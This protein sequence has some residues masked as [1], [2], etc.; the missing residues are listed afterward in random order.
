M[1]KPAV[2]KSPLTH[3]PLLLTREMPYVLPPMEFLAILLFSLPLQADTGDLRY[4]LETLYNEVDLLVR[5]QRSDQSGRARIERAFKALKVFDRI[6]MQPKIDTL[7]AELAHRAEEAGVGLVK[8]EVLGKD[9]PKK[10]LP[11]VLVSDTPHFA[12]SPDQIAE[13]LHLRLTIKGDPSLIEQWIQKWP[14]DQLRLIEPESGYA[15]PGLA[16]AGKDR[17]QL[18]ARAYRFREIHFPTLKAHDPLDLLPEWARRN[19][20]SFAASQ[21]ALWEYVKKIQEAIPRTSSP[22]E[23]KGDLLLNSA[24]MDFFLS[25]AK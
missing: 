7:R 16:H 8:L 14:E 13:T 18:R 22:F 23:T 1:I 19:P 9:R 15:R 11:R 10:A 6:P 17:F 21:P 5:N 4:R 25:K 20:V 3:L 24:R 12:L 2:K